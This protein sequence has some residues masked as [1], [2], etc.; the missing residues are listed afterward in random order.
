MKAQRNNIIAIAAAALFVAGAVATQPACSKKSAW[1]VK[2]DKLIAE[3][4]I[5]VRTRSDIP[6]IK[7]KP[8][9]A[10]GV[11]TAVA[12]LP[13]TELAPGVKARIYWGKGNLVAWLTLAPGAKIPKETLPA[14]R[15][16]VVMKGEIG[17]LLKGNYVTMQAVPRDEPDGTHG[18]TPKNEFILLEKGVENG[19]QAYANAAEIVEI[20][21]PPRTDYLVKA[22]ASDV[23]VE[24]PTPVFPI[25]PTVAPGTVYDLHDIPFTELQPGANSRLIGGRGAQLS[26]LRMD[27]GMS[28]AEHLH[29]EEQLMIVLR[30]SIDEIILD[31]TA[32]MKQGDLLYLPAAWVHGG[33]VGD[34]GCDVLDVFFPPRPDYMGKKLDREAVFQAVIP[35]DAK[36]ELF[37]DGAKTK[38][39]LIFCEGPKWLNGKLYLSSMAFDQKWNGDPGRSTTVEVDPDGAY[40][41]ISKGMLT[42]GLLPLPNGNLAA[43]DMFGHRVIEMTTSGRVVRT[44]ASAFEGKPIDGPNDLVG[45]TKGGLYF[46]DPQFTSEARKFQPGRSVFYITPQGKLIRII[47]PNDFAMPNGILLSPDGKTLLVN[48]TYDNESFWNV[49]SDKDNW[50]WA[51]DVNDDGTVKNPRKFAPLVLTPEVTDRKGRS[52]AA[53]GMT[54][55]EKGGIYV[56][57]YMG[58]QVFSPKGEFLG[59][60]NTPTY[61]VSCCFGGADMKTLY[62]VSYD[63]IYRIKT[64][65]TGLKYG[66]K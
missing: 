62:I 37:V 52:S 55:D 31:A 28:F 32:P 6:A 47:P 38:P 49:D 9:L 10:E 36:V 7:L 60:I 29:P 63:K 4:K 58:V 11:A 39:G 61:P 23:P 22:G 15:I 40:R 12:S 14:D 41:Y 65:V 50:V 26:F 54:M 24:F 1:A 19:I 35:A 13:E 59:I 53:D 48:N 18:R 20:Y 64:N 16:M 21:W 51:Y 2:N 57:T 5:A 25:A 56:A 66:P 42:N 44:L 34:R 3:K 27:P 46:T 33:K 8:G 30:G 43:C 17:Q 45:D